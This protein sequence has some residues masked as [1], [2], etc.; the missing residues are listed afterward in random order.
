MNKVS[1]VVGIDEVGRGPLAGP[2]TVGICAVPHDFDALSLF[3]DGVCK[4]S[5]KLTEKERDA[6]YAALPSMCLYTTASLDAVYIDEH[7]IVPAIKACVAECM[8]YLFAQKLSKQSMMV[9]CDGLLKVED[10]VIKQETVIQGDEKIPVIALASII[11][12]VTR[13]KEMRLHAQN[14]KLYGFESNVGYGTKK[15]IDAIKSQGLTPLHRKTFLKK[16]V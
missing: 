3:P 9:Y 13:D 8:E 7:G 2:V 11:A 12:K 4:D 5:K 16:Y 14:Y 1:Y 6:I 15:H 10:A